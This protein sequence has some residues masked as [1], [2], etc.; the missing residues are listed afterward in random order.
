MRRTIVFL[1]FLLAPV[2]AMAQI[3]D[4]FDDF[5]PQTSFDGFRQNMEQR[6]S[7]FQDTM[8][9]RFAKELSRQWIEYECFDGEVRARKPKPAQ[10]PVAPQQ[11][12][13]SSDEL[14][15]GNI[16]ESA[17]E[18]K[19]VR[20][21]PESAPTPEASPAPEATTSSLMSLAPLTFFSQQLSCVC[22]K[23]YADLQLDGITEK[24]VS[25]FWKALACEGFNEF[26]QQCRSQ[27]A[28]LQLNDWGLFELAKSYG[29]QIFGDNYAAQTVFTV[30]ILNQLGFDARVGRVGGQLVCLLPSA[31]KMYAVSFIRNNDAPLYVFSLYPKPTREGSVFTYNAQFPQAKNTIDLHIRKPLQLANKPADKTFAARFCGE[32]IS[33]P[34]NE[35]IIRFYETYPQADLAIYAGAQ[36]DVNWSERMKGALSSALDEKNDF[37]KVALLLSFL[38]KS[39]P[40]Q[41]DDEQF[42]KEKTFFCE[43]NFYYSANDCEDRSVLFSYLVRNLVGLDVILL[44]YPDHIATAVHFNDPSVAGDYYLYQGKKYIVC[45]PTYIGAFVG[46]TMPQYKNIKADIIEIGK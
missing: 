35:R 31:C 23:Q 7:E 21:I 28:Q 29:Q 44:D 25:A 39:F 2:L 9:S 17:P 33:V 45:D 43:E 5:A 30:F 15:A 10:L 46:E 26:V 4:E 37:E 24:S 41:T 14:P 20:P 8:N 42:G 11:H 13:V 27:Q 3:T 19:P 36:P 32:S 16:Q 1:L 18:P 22:P 6:F 12:R 34:V 38:H 40:Y